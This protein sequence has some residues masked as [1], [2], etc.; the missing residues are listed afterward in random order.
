MFAV[1]RYQIE[2]PAFHP[3]TSKFDYWLEGKARLHP[4]GAARLPAVQRSRQGAIAAAAIS[5]SPAPD[6]LPPLFTDHQFEALGVPRNPALRANRDPHYFDLGLCGPYRADHARPRRSI[7]ACSSRPRCATSR[8]GTCS[9][10]TASITHL[11]QV[12]DFY[13]FRDIAPGK[14]YPRGAGRHGREVR[15]PA[16]RGIAPMSMS[17]IRRSTAARRHA[18]DE[19]ARTKRDIIAFL[20]TLTDGY[21]PRGAGR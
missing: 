3:Y 19:R 15:R 1:A 17:P 20:R 21:R 8:R 16:G 2:D 14:V 6:G 4:G 18:G 13:D 11:Q 5:I 10:T 7:A 12:L 9:S